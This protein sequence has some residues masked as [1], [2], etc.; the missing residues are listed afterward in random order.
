[1]LSD[2]AELEV[3]KKVYQALR[4]TGKAHTQDLEKDSVE[5][6]DYMKHQRQVEMKSSL[7]QEKSVRRW[8]AHRFLEHRKQTSVSI[9]YLPGRSI[10]FSFWN[11]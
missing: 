10:F 5:V 4:D 9:P 7:E 8:P 11:S 2:T 6:L 1:M 3:V